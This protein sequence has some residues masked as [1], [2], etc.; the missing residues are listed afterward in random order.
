MG[1][2]NGDVEPTIKPILVHKYVKLWPREV[3]YI[4]DTGIQRQL[5]GVLKESGV[6]ILYLDFDVFYIG[7]ADNLFRR[8]CEHAAKRYWLWNHFSSFVVDQE[9][10]A[11]VEA[12]MIAATPRTANK[13][14]GK[15]FRRIDLPAEI[16]SVLD[17]ARGIPTTES[18]V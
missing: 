13:S 18:Q 8:L 3:F 5:R 4:P 9:H 15:V 14:G 1:R 11:E 17:G 6:Y 7:K 2:A 16:K 10:L 12:I